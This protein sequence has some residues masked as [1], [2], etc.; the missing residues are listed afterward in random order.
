MSTTDSE[1]DGDEEREDRSIYSNESI[2]DIFRNTSSRFKVFR[3]P[4]KRVS[5]PLYIVMLIVILYVYIGSLVLNFLE[6]WNFTQAVY[7]SFV[8][9]STIGMYTE[10]KKI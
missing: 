8:S 5:I 7:F 4:I 1:D 2:E 10:T 9:M 3:K 6:G